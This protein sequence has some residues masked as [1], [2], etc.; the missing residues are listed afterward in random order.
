MCPVHSAD[1]RRPGHLA[2]G[3]PVY[4]VGRQYARAARV[5]Y[6]HHDSRVTEEAAATHQYYMDCGHYG[7]GRLPSCCWHEI[8]L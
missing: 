2:G 5:H 3:V 6:A 7:A 4:S 1:G 8:L